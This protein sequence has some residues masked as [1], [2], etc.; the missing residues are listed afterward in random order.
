MSMNVFRL[1]ADLAHISSKCI[2]IWAIHRNN[3]SEG[4]SLLTQILYGLVFL[5]RYLD[6]FSTSHWA[7]YHAYNIFFK[8]F[9]IFS[10]LYIIYV[11]I[12][13]F[14]RTRERE[15]SWKLASLCFLGALVAA[16]SALGIDAAIRRKSY[17]HEWFTETCWAF[18]IVLESVCVLPQLLLLRQTTVPTVIDSFYLVALGSY[19]ALYI[20]N[21][22]IRGFGPEHYWDPIADIFGVVQTLFYLDFAW[23]Y[24]TRQRV[25]L[26]RGGIV[27]SDDLRKSWFV[28]KILN[29]RRINTHDDENEPLDPEAAGEEESRPRW[30]GRG[31]SVSADDTLENHGRRSPES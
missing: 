8:L 20:L 5:T 23:V 11:M 26:R 22:L 28:G 1:L 2:L 13:V 31:I 6:L 19:R 30:G 21:W 16:P 27:D 12:Y 3:S 15:K 14:P 9:Y 18:S 7:F 25:K 4:V 10:S 29:S 24:Y 17:P